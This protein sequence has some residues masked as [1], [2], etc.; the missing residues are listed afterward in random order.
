[1]RRM[2]WVAVALLVCVSAAQPAQGEKRI[3]LL[4]GN[5]GY[6]ASVGKL[7]NPHNDIAAVGQALAAQGFELLQGDHAIDRGAAAFL[8]EIE[9]R[10]LDAPALGAD[11]AD[12]AA[13]E[14]EAA[15]LVGAEPRRAHHPV[16]GT[17]RRRCGLRLDVQS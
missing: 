16:G 13:H 15:G 3:A 5:Q 9:P 7:K 6:D 17:Q 4:I 1:M 10:P 12:E 2:A 8:I 14:A 11:P